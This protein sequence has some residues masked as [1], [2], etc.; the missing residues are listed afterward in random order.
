MK[1]SK[2]NE[3]TN[4]QGFANKIQRKA[5]KQ[6]ANISENELFYFFALPE[7][8]IIKNSL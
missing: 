3:I 6:L 7:H 2:M 4:P 5:D 1:Q 8:D